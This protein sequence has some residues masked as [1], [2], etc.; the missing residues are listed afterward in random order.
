MI[1]L[2]PCHFCGGNGKLNWHQ[3]KYYG[4]NVF[5]AKKIKFTGYIFCTKCRSRG[6]PV[7]VISDRVNC[8]GW[9]TE[10]RDAL[11]PK[12]AEAWN[13][14]AT[15][16]S[17]LANVTV[18]G[19]NV[20]EELLQALKKSEILCADSGDVTAQGWRPGSETPKVTGYYIAIT[21]DGT[22]PRELFWSAKRQ[23]WLEVSDGDFDTAYA[24]THWM[25]M[26][27]PPKEEA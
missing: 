15:P 3:S 18:F 2:K 23:K 21:Q 20:S 1:R 6:A 14:R 16:S 19:D 12:A 24:V 4:Q 8:R 22:Y 9:E 17:P 7:S 13:R 11:F 26:P 5:G 10:L 25:P 27:E